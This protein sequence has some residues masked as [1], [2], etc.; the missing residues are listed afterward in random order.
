MTR[1]AVAIL[2]AS[3]VALAAGCG[4]SP[5]QKAAEQ[6]AQAAKDTKQ[7]AQDMAKGLQQLTQG[8]QQMAQGAAG[9]ASGQ[10]ATPVDF[11]KLETV[12][13]SVGGWT[14]GEPEGHSL[15]MPFAMSNTEATY[16]KDT[17]EVR[18]TITD[19]AFSQLAMA[20]L[21]MMTAAGYAEKTSNGYKKASMVNG[22]PGYEEWRKDDKSG[23]IGVI[24]N[25]R[26][27]IDAKGS[28]LDSIDTL[29]DF[30]QKIDLNKL[31]AL[32]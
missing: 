22:M 32:K 2:L 6:Q 26:F 24:V 12:L 21:M 25:K 27:M 17:S 5:E 28:N 15:T 1:H 18:L 29:K 10:A 23:T 14:R 31:G 3:A 19:S 7:G 11:E 16:K 13:P 9:Q 8:L 30:V 20:P 4:K